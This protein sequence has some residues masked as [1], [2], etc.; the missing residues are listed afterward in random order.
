M[1]ESLH[2]SL[3]R[4][5]EESI[6]SKCARFNTKPLG[7]IDVDFEK[8]SPD[9]VTEQI[10]EQVP[11]IAID[12]GR[13]PITLENLSKERME[14]VFPLLCIISPPLLFEALLVT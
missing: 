14:E 11:S 4:V 1:D 3:H 9:F 13:S 7:K 12:D 10:P 8:V 2:I 6:T 5:C